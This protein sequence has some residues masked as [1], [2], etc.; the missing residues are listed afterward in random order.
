MIM[1]LYRT[2]EWKVRDELAKCVLNM[3][4]LGIFFHFLIGILMVA[5]P[6]I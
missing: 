1:K 6:G 4:L 2:H 3:A 5:D